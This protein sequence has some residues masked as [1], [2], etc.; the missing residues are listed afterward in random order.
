MEAFVRLVS[1]FASIRIG[2]ASVRIRVSLQRYRMASLKMIGWRSGLPLRSANYV[3]LNFSPVRL[4]QRMP[5]F[6]RIPSRYVMLQLPLNISQQA[7]GPKTKHLRP[8]PR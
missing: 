1:S 2:S 7:A 5:M 6:R 4:C 3:E 8:H